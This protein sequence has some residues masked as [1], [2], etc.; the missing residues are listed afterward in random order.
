MSADYTDD[1]AVLFLML[2]TRSLVCNASCLSAARHIGSLGPVRART[3]W[4]FGLIPKV[5]RWREWKL[6]AADEQR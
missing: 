5:G 3:L 2:V 1:P 6:M 4:Y